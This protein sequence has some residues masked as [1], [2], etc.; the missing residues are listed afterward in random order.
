[1]RDYARKIYLGLEY[2]V[3]FFGL[4]LLLL[5]TI[6]IMHPSSILVPIVVLIVFYLKKQNFHWREIKMIKVP[7]KFLLVNIFLI[8]LSSAIIFAWVYFNFQ[9]DLFNL[10]QQNLR[11]WLLLVL[12]YPLFSASLQE[13]I[14]RVFMFRRYRELFKKPWVIIVASGLAFSFAHIFY[15][16]VLSLLLTLIMGIYLAY[17][18]F[19]TRSF[20]LVSLIHSFYGVF[21]FTIGLGELFWIDMQKHLV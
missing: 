6:N 18:Y 11:I 15:L 8:F 9:E 10:P 16:N 13:V 2:L 19:R 21:V 14:Y 12:L 7:A 1:M 20:L 3:L 5:Y 17:L 4:P